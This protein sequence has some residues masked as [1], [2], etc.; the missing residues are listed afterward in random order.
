M[1]PSRLYKKEYAEKSVADMT[2]NE[3]CGWT[4]KAVPWGKWYAIQVFDDEGVMV[5]YL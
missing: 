4:Y 1:R 2:A 5:G 3:T